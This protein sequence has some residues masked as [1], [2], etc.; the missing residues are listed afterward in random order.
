MKI[1]VGSVEHQALTLFG[2]S[3]DG[4]VQLTIRL[5]IDEISKLLGYLEDAA[6]VMRLLKPGEKT[7][8]I[9][10]GGGAPSP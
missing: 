8:P 9:R 1:G 4:Q 6:D 3:D 7:G 5:T 10:P 2:Y